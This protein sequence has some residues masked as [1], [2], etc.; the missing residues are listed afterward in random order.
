MVA[1][2]TRVQGVTTLEEARDQLYQEAPDEFVARR[3]ALAKELRAA[4]DKES[5]AALKAERRPTRLLWALRTAAT[6]D[7]EL[8]DRFVDAATATAAAQEGGGDLRA[9]TAELRAAIGDLAKATGTRA[10]IDRAD[11]ASALLAVAGDDEAA[12]DLRAGRLRD[13]PESGFGPLPTA[14]TATATA[15]PEPEPPPPPKPDPAAVK[16]AKAAR[17]RVDDARVTVDSAERALA[18]ARA[19]LADAEADLKEAEAAL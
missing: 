1:A 13:V 8:V 16:R 9:A 4:G 19:E 18:E 10:G 7:A 11:V 12:A 15:T 6:V 3:D 14:A 17:Q 2:A 5:A